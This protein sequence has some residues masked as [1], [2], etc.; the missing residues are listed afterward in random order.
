MKPNV[1][2]LMHILTAAILLAV[3]GSGAVSADA[4]GDRAAAVT[5]NVAVIPAN[6]QDLSFCQPDPRAWLEYL[7]NSFV[8]NPDDGTGS[9]STY[10]ED[11]LGSSFQFRFSILSPVTLP[12]RAVY[13]GGNNSSGSDSHPN[14]LFTHACAAAEAAG[15]NFS[16]FD[17]DGDDVI[18]LVFVIFPGGNEAESDVEDE[19]W[20][21]NDN[22]E[23]LRKSYSGK[24]LGEVACYSEFTGPD[25][26]LT[27]GIGTICHELLHTLGLPDL[28]DVNGDAEGKADALFGSISI[29]DRGNLNN[30]GRT[31]PYLS[32]V[33][34]ELLGLL[35]TELAVPGSQYFLPS[36]DISNT[37]LKIST[38][39][40]GEYFLIEY[41]SGT[42]WDSYIGGS[43]LLVYHIDKSLN[44]AGS[45]TAAERWE[46]NAI[47]CC[48]AHPC[49]QLVDITA[50][51]Q[52]QAVFY[53]GSSGTTVIVSNENEA[54][55]KWDGDGAGYGLRNITET[56]SGAAEFNIV[57]DI[58]WDLP[59]VLECN[60]FANQRDARIEWEA[61]KESAA[62]WLIRWGSARSIFMETVYPEGL[63]HTFSNLAPGETYICDILATEDGIEGKKYH[64]EFTTIPD[65]TDY[66]LISIP[67]NPFEVGDILRLN[68]INIDGE[69]VAQTWYY[70]GQ[71][72]SGPT[73][74][75]TDRGKH[76]IG[77]RYSMDGETYEQMEKTVTVE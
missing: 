8:I 44:I 28:Y 67:K 73:I 37:A 35:H 6:F 23:R 11:N 71:P 17:S 61:D 27:A 24:R 51:G 29:M 43:G 60:V 54:L 45:M 21:M 46:V 33:E 9:V 68:I 13:Y 7:F 32:A 56:H 76:L 40:E 3:A 59:R 20:P 34:R 41:R 48:A 62:T 22:L 58:Y 1:K 74:T 14:E 66:P 4:S 38:D 53:P 15:V 10:L 55:W 30:D 42:K 65:L 31:P 49:V 39:N 5:L 52:I 19:I 57:P 64:I 69:P 63:E 18:D 2:R 12:E 75:F 77:V 25:R 36:I 26:T 47:N 16:R 50:A 72:C 70:D